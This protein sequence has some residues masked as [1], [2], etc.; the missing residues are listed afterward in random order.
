MLKLNLK[1]FHFAQ[2]LLR[3]QTSPGKELLPLLCENCLTACPY[4]HWRFLFFPKILLEFPSTLTSVHCLSFS[5]CPSLRKVT[6][7][8]Y[9]SPNLPLL[10]DKQIQ[11]SQ[12]LILLVL[13]PWL[14]CQ[15]SLRFIQVCQYLSCT[16]LPQTGHRTSDFVSYI[17]D[18][19]EES[20]PSNCCLHFY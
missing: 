4:P 13:V 19:S 6:L 7:R 5:C 9:L 14:S 12:P 18:S 3:V 8:K 15:S 20:L 2:G 10:Q 17:P 11:F 16:T 1:L